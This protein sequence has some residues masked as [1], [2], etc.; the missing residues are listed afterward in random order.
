MSS[1]VYDLKLATITVTPDTVT[2]QH[3]RGTVHSGKTKELQLKSISGIELQEPGVIMAG[4]IQFMF[5]GGKESNAIKR[6]DVAKHENTVMIGK[7]EFHKAQE[8]RDAVNAYM[9]QSKSAPVAAAPLSDADELKKWAD[10]RD[11][12]V[13]SAEDFEAKKK[14]IIGL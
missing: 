4:Y 3:K 1:Q 9:K 7:K 12:G 14:Q 5:S 13:I 6:T 10:L 11:S 8:I 2:I